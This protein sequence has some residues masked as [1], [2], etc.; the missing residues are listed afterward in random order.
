MKQLS[1]ILVTLLCSV[2]ITAHAAQPRYKLVAGKGYSVCEAYLKHLNVLSVK[3]SPP[4]CE[5]KLSPQ[6]KNFRFPEWEALDW[7]GH[8][9]W[10][11]QLEQLLYHANA[12]DEALKRL[13]FPDWQ[14]NYLARVD[15]GELKPRLR[16]AQ[17]TL[18]ERGSET[19]LDYDRRVGSCDESPPSQFGAD[20]GSHYFVVVNGA[21]LR[22]ELIA[23]WP[24]TSHMILFN[25]RAYFM[26]FEQYGPWSLTMH[27]VYPLAPEPHPG[28]PRYNMNG[29]NNICSYLPNKKLKK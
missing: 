20:G 1:L 2:A 4:V 15:S 19:I 10:I 27:T 5:V 17:V 29:F 13:G 11:Y 24:Q 18:N 21:P 23:G 28:A 14:K 25:G 26:D 12:D 8:L 9:D 22:F 7:Q 3:E 6:F 16:R